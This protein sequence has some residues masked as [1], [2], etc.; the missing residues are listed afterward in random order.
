MK[1]DTKQENALVVGGTATTMG[2]NK[3]DPSVFVQMLISLYQFPIEAAVR[4]ALSNSWDSVVAA[5]SNVPP[6]VGLTKDKFFVQDFGTGMSPEFMLS[7]TEGFSTIGYSTKR[8]RDDQLGYWGFGKVVALSYTR[9][10]FWLHTVWEG[11]AYE[12]LVFLDGN[13]IKVLP[14]KEEPTEEPNGTRVVVQLKKEWKEFDKWKEAIK[15]Q[16]AYFEGTVIDI[17][18]EKEVVAIEKNNFVWTSSLYKGET[19]LI[20]GSVYYD[21]PW[22]KL[23]EWNV[24]RDLNIG[25]HFNLTEGITPVPSREA[26]EFNETSKELLIS[27][28]KTILE[29]I[30]VQCEKE[31][32]EVQTKSNMEKLKFVYNKQLS[33]C[34]IEQYNNICKALGKT[35][36]EIVIDDRIKGSERSLFIGLRNSFKGT[37][38][39][40]Q[41]WTPLKREYVRS[42]GYD[43]AERTKVKLDLYWYFNTSV[44]PVDRRTLAEQL[45]EQYLSEWID[46][47][48]TKFDE[49]GFQEWK[50][51]RKSVKKVSKGVVY[52]R[53]HLNKNGACT[54]DKGDIDLS[55]YRYVFKAWEVNAKRYWPFLNRTF[56]NFIITKDYGMD[57]NNLEPSPLLKRMCSEALKF[58]IYNILG[59]RTNDKKIREIIKDLNP[60]LAQYM[61][62]VP[63][64]EGTYDGVH[65]ALVETG[66]KFGCFDKDEVKLRYMEHHL[67][68]LEFCKYV[69]FKEYSWSDLKLGE[70]EVRIIKRHYILERLAEKKW[71]EEQ[72]V[73]TNQLEIQFT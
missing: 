38:V 3:L 47:H 7:S 33:L 26:W 41:S 23:S 1:I 49:V 5:G 72:P 64:K 58:K 17:E 70:N 32:V 19:H 8:D 39:Y 56:K 46:F 2:L 11:K 71:K 31:L 53:E 21:I 22:N 67:K 9:D 6:V 51:N 16:C 55:N 68:L 18:G 60:L 54:Q 12:Y 48:Y 66:E 35:P 73:N 20:L 57:L 4:E 50:K 52:Y 36:I 45:K 10:Q 30:H 43:C 28:F 65:M 44:A 59:N 34:T 61:E 37:G 15:Q 63:L 14:L 62:E 24:V 27:K 29:Q 42:L 69:G 25:I 40:C 13:T